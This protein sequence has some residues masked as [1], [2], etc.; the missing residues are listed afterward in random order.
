MSDKKS[1]M[2]EFEYLIALLRAMLKSEQPPELLDDCDFGRVFVLAKH[3]SVAGMAYYAAEKL[4][5]PPLGALAAEWRQVRDKALVKDITQ[6]A[7]L[8]AIGG[9]LSANGVRYLPLKGSIIKHLYPQS[10][11]RTMSDIDLLIDPENAAQARDIMERLGY[12]CEKFGHD[13]HDIYHKPPVMN[14][15]IHRELFGDEGKEFK[16]VFGDPW[17]L[18]ERKDGLRFDFS[19][20]AFF[21]YVLAHAVKHLEEG[22]TGIR[23]I[24]DLWVCLHSDMNIDIE[25]SLRLLEK[26]GKRAAAQ[27]LTELSEVWFDEKPINDETHDLERYILGSGTYGTISN[28]V[29]NKIEKSGKIKYLLRLVFPTFAHMRQQYPVLAKAPALLPACWFVRLITKPFV[30]HRQNSQKLKEILKK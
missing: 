28:S 11:M 18:C 30:N 21:A 6:Q 9:A 12:S 24:M 1:D 2:T 29:A 13:I 17:Q 20:D 3:H 25:K 14:V 7:E 15:E 8:E 22:G 16:S 26:S 10:D 4:N 27:K 19:A 5:A 23:T